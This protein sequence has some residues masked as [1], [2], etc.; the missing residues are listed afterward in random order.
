MIRDVTGSYDLAW[1]LAG[2]LCMAAAV[3][4]ISIRRNLPPAPAA[5]PDPQQAAAAQAHG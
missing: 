2:A 3:M 5:P 1:F 4:S